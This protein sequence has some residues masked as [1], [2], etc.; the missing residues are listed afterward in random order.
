MDLIHY[1]SLLHSGYRLGLLLGVHRVDLVLDVG[2]NVGQFATM[3]REYGYAGRIASFE[4]MSEE[5]RQLA[6]A[7]EADDAWSVHRYALGET[8]STAT[9]HVAGN[10]ISSSLLPMLDS[11]AHAAPASQYRRSE[12]IEVRPLDDVFDEVTA[13]A[14]RPFLKIDTQGF[15]KQVLAGAAG[16]LDGIVGLQMEMTLVPL[17][18]GQMLFQEALATAEDLGFRMFGVE[19]GFTDPRNGRMLQMDG[20]F[21]RDDD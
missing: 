12:Q 16:R 14:A 20:I 13:G 21:F 1:P 10:S 15:E 5:F 17:Y 3:L 19:P 7:A 4:P 6:A 11:H 18:D 8:A 2:A 9:I